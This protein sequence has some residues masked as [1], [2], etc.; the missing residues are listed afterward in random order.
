MTRISV[1]FGFKYGTPVDADIVLDV[2]FLEN[3]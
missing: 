3:P 1:S 2:R